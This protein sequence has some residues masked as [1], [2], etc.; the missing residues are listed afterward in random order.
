MKEFLKNL[1]DLI[2]SLFVKEVKE[3]EMP[4]EKSMAGVRVEAAK[5]ERI[6]GILIEGLSNERGAQIDD[7]VF[8]PH[9]ERY[10]CP[11]LRAM[12]EGYIIVGVEM[13]GEMLN[14]YE[15]T[16]TV[17]T[18]DFSKDEVEN[19]RV[20]T[21]RFRLPR[22]TNKLLPGVHEFKVKLGKMPRE[23]ESPTYQHKHDSVVWIGE[24]EISVIFA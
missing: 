16:S 7:I 14:F 21:P 17:C 13:D 23:G 11:M 18:T 4:I 22:Y 24:R 19:D 20:T 5:K 1:I 10:I 9:G 3:Q 12:E 2:M 6:P 8:N 15:T